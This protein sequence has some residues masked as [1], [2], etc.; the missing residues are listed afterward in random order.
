MLPLS[1]LLAPFAMVVAIL[2]TYGFLVTWSL[3]RFGGETMA[4]GA[5]V[6]YWG[7]T[8][9]VLFLGWYALSGIDWSAPFLDLSSFGAPSF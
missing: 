5:T 3:Y 9:I 6:I 8:A 2:L 1:V 7:G 4:Y